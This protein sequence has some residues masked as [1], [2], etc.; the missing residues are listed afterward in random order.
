MP[1]G[2]PTLALDLATITGWAYYNNLF[3]ASATHEFLWSPEETLGSRLVQY[4][5]WL[6]GML[7]KSKAKLVVYEKP[8]L[9]GGGSYLLSGLASTTELMATQHRCWCDS[10]H[11]GTLKKYATG[12]GKASKIEMVEAAEK[13]F[14]FRPVDDNHADALWLLDYA[15]T[16]VWKT[17]K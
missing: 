17:L 13:K 8:H 3:Q 1:K 9:R 10:V 7:K 4:V 15:K 11:T 16:H 2:I 5:E 6:E 12:K 14:G